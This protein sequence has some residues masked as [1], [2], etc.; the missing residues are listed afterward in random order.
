MNISEADLRRISVLDEMARRAM[1][2][3]ADEHVINEATGAIKALLKLLAK[4]GLNLSDIPA[5]RARADAAE[6]AKTTAAASA[7][8]DENAPALIELIQHVLTCWGD[9]EPHQSIGIVLWIL[10]THVVKHFQVSPRLALLSPCRCCGKSTL[11]KLI[12][13]LVPNPERHVNIS[14]ASIYRLIDEHVGEL[15]FLFDEADNAGLKIDRVMRAVLNDGHVKGG[16]ITRT[17]Q[18]QTKSFSTFAPTAIAAIGTLPLPLMERSV[19]ILMQRTT[20][21]DL[22][23]VEDF[24][25]PEEIA[26]LDALRHL[27]ANWA[28]NMT[29]FNIQPPIPRVLRNRPA[30]NWRVLLAIVDSFGDAHWS[31]LAREAA[32]IFA[33][34]HHDEDACV[35]LLHDIR[36]ILRRLKAD[37]IKSATLAEELHELEDG[38]GIWSA[39]R[40]ENDDQAPH[41]ITQG[42][43]ATLLRRFDRNLRPKPLFE[44]G[45]RETRGKT[46]RGYYASQFERWWLRYCPEEGA[47]TDNVRQLRLKSESECE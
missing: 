13:K 29:Q 44:L 27:I 31:K 46:A 3:S 33:D 4:Y 39:W 21:I 28:R 16:L 23:T 7:T 6:A 37:R 17:I 38:L 43:I 35:A 9:V 30:D 8:P 19:V 15:T 18:G 22:K 45:S 20:R 42:E 34:G 36:M 10:S 24:G 25:S 11:L 41:P 40:G 2:E 32:E 1:E 47:S 5:L 26:R 12:E 14:A